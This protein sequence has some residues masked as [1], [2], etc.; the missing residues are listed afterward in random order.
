MSLALDYSSQD[1]I[2]FHIYNY[3]VKLLISLELILKLIIT[4][5]EFRNNWLILYS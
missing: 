1:K 4:Q 2:I 3:N 5:T